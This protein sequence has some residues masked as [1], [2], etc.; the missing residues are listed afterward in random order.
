MGWAVT[1]YGVCADDMAGDGC[2]VHVGTSQG[3]S[4]GRHAGRC[5]RHAGG[6]MSGQRVQSNDFLINR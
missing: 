5:S 4:D 2:R 1:F 3:W 6:E